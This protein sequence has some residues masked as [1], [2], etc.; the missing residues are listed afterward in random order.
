MTLNP[1]RIGRTMPHGY[2]GVYARQPDMIVNTRPAGAALRFGQG[3]VYNEKGQVVLPGA[4]SKAADFVGVAAAEVKTATNYLT[5]SA[6]GYVPDEPVSVF[7]RGAINAK[8]Q[9]G[10]A[11]LGGAVY[12]RI[13]A[14]EALPNAVVG[15]FEAA[16][17]GANSVQ[18]TNCEW[19][20][21]ADADGIAGLRIKTMNR[22]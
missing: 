16:A 20:G 13:T 21:A 14:N 7:Q 1:Q 9:N 5:Q 2:A 10:S 15:G 18:L 4:D 19:A 3:L 11:A 12:L 17:D 22:A 8:C 6:G